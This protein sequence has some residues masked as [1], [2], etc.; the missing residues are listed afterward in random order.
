MLYR[1]TVV[2]DIRLMGTVNGKKTINLIFHSKIILVKVSFP[3]CTFFF[4]QNLKYAVTTSLHSTHL[5]KPLK[6]S[7]LASHLHDLWEKGGGHAPA[8]CCFFCLCGEDSG[9]RNYKVWYLVRMR[10]GRS[11]LIATVN[12]ISTHSTHANRVYWVEGT[13]LL[14][15]TQDQCITGWSSAKAKVGRWPFAGPQPLLAPGCCWP[16]ALVCFWYSAVLSQVCNLLPELCFRGWGEC[17]TCM[18]ANQ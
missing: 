18:V 11:H 13:S 14:S 16:W 6:M 17:L 3:F 5:E 2:H 9:Y 12:L 1:C 4:T 7:V 8:H 15:Y 10:F